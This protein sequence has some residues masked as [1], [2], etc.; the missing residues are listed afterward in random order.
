LSSFPD[1]PPH[2]STRRTYIDWAR[3]LAVLIM[4][5][6]HVLDSWTLRSARDTAAFGYLN[7]LGGFAAPLFLW[8]AGIGLMISAERALVRSGDR[9]TAASGVIRR[10][11]EIFLLAFL[12]RLQAFIVSPGNPPVSLLRVD[13][14]NIMGPALVGTALVWWVARGSKSAVALCG[15]V[16]AMFAMLTPIARTAPVLELLP[17]ALQ[18]YVSPNGNHSTFTLFPWAGFV[19]AGAAYGALLVGVDTRDEGRGLRRLATAGALLAAGCYYAASFPSIYQASSF[20]TTSP[21]YFGIRV[22]LLMVALWGLF[23]LTPLAASFPRSFAV[24]ER[25]GRHSLFVYWIHV[26][27]V[28]G[29]ATVLIH[30]RLPLWGTALGYVTFCGALYW[31]IALK[32]R[33]VAWWRSRPRSSSTLETLRT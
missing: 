3:G 8:L 13:I 1:N 6:A 10:G 2:V 5:E 11:F 22:G 32:D 19:F 25:F 15:A 9:A 21:T 17:A 24:L 31:A 12:F 33:A 4:I 30:H 7:L 29:Y 27:L 26:E 18:W 28:Y 23:C 20:W 16:A 14:L